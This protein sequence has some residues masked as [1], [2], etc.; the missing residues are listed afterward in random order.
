VIF[1]SHTHADKALVDTIAQK[2]AAVFGQ[3]S[4]FYDSW[5]IQPG[6]GIIDR[7]N[8]GLSD[9][10]FFFFF[11]SK[12][13]LQS[14]LVQ[15]EWQNALLKS[16]K[17]E[18]K[19]IPVRIDDVLMPPVLLQTLYIDVFTQGLETGV[20]QM[21]DVISGR[22]TYQSASIEGFA[23]IRAYVRRSPDKL[24]VEFRAEAYMEPHSRYLILFGNTEDQLSWAAPGEGVFESGFNKNITLNDGRKVNALLMARSSATSPGFPFIVEISSKQ[25]AAIQFL[26]AM[27]IVSRDQFGGIPVIEAGNA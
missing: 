3:G 4:I 7:M 15:L 13:S 1:L 2:L 12:K 17:G 11:V 9:C 6:D 19:I 14:K 20:R 10:R 16:T 24:V 27:R 26:G 8:A 18:T 22:N 21:V 25:N 23:N 5:A